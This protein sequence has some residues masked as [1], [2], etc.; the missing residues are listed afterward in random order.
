MKRS[1]FM[2]PVCWVSA[3]I[4]A[5]GAFAQAPERDRR[6]RPDRPARRGEEGDFWRREDVVTRLDLTPAQRSKLDGIAGRFREETAEL[7][8]ELREARSEFNVLLEQPDLNRYDL[9]TLI[10]DIIDLQA[11]IT[12]LNLERRIAVR[13]VLTAEQHVRL[14]TVRR[15]RVRTVGERIRERDR[16][17][18]DP[19][20]E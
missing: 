3:L 18:D 8:S 11:R 10:G 14:R 7:Q 2:I 1:V 16:L 6:E 20:E 9:E 12:R 5:A 15:E 4:L 17:E 19:E 13:E